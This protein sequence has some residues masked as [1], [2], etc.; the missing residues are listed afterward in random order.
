[1]RQR[2]VKVDFTAEA[3]DLTKVAQLVGRALPVKGPLKISGFLSDTAPK[4]FKV[5]KMNIALGESDIGGSVKLRLGDKR[6]GLDAALT[7]KRLAR[8]PSLAGGDGIELPE[9]EEPK[10]KKKDKVFSAEALPLGALRQVNGSVEVKVSKLLLP[11]LVVDDL[12]L[13]LNLNKGYLTVKLLKASVGGGGVIGHG[14]DGAPVPKI[15]GSSL[16]RAV[17]CQVCGG[18]PSTPVIQVWV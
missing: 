3:G 13:Y 16:A 6:L 8:R 18:S 12:D 14:Q 15:S 2:G 17:S 5:S 9:G 4:T 10:G 11:G 1:M 7:A